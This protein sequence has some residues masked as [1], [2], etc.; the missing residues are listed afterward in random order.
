MRASLGQPSV[1]FGQPFSIESAFNQKSKREVIGAVCLFF[2]CHFSVGSGNAAEIFFLSKGKTT[3]F[4]PMAPDLIRAQHPVGK[5]RPNT[6][7]IL[8]V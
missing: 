6:V 7:D 5:T 2:N 3:L 4:W 8:V 1:L